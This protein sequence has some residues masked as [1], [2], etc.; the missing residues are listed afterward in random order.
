D[1]PQPAPGQGASEGQ[2]EPSA[3]TRSSWRRYL[4]LGDGN[5]TATAIIAPVVVTVI[6]LGVAGGF[7]W[8]GDQLKEDKPPIHVSGSRSPRVAVSTKP[9][10][11][12]SA[13]VSS[14]VPA[15]PSPEPHTSSSAADIDQADQSEAEAQG[16]QSLRDA[17]LCPWEAWVV[18]RP[19]SDFNE[20][21]VVEGGSPDPE[22]INDETAGDPGTTHLLIDIQP[23]DSRPLQIKEIRIKILERTPAPTAEE[24]TLVGLQNGQCGEPPAT[25]DAYAD[26]DGGADF[27]TVTFDGGETLPQEIVDGRQ[28]AVNLTVET[29]TCDCLWVP[30][31]VWSKDGEVKTTEFRIDGKDFRTIATDGLER[32]AWQQDLNTLEW[33]E[34]VFDETILD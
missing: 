7:S 3:S 16:I 2:A 6:G 29:R 10:A 24:A 34:I 25:L 14:S 22:I 12:P 26:L 30:E 32:R 4:P 11:Q 9:G 28:L 13:T 18:N 27:A 20:V 17:Y 21:P 31:I 19:P 5:F 23:V 1:A 8:I 15:T 33:S